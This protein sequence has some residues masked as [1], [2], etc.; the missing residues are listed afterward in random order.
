MASRPDA[1][2]GHSVGELSAAHVAGVLNLSDAAMLVCARGRLMQRCERGGS[3]LSLE[4][5]E[6]EVR[7]ELQ[8]QGPLEVDIAGLNGPRQTVISGAVEAVQALA[9]AFARQGRRII[10]L[11]VSHAFHSLHME[12]MLAE[13]ERVAASCTFFPAR[14]PVV[15]LLTG[16]LASD[17]ELSSPRYWSR[18]VRE[19][20]RFTDGIAALHAEGVRLFLECGPDAVLSALGTGC[21]PESAETRF[22]SSL[23]KGQSD[24]LAVQNA[25]AQLHVSG[26]EPN[27]QAVF[28]GARPLVTLPTYAFQHERHWLE[29]GHVRADL[30]PIGMSEL[31]HRVLKFAVPMADSDGSI[32]QGRSATRD[33]D[34][35]LAVAGSR[36]LLFAP[37]ATLD[38][39]L[40]AAQ[41]LGE[42]EVR[43]LELLEPVTCPED[44]AVQFQLSIGKSEPSGERHFS[45]HARGERDG[46]PWI[47]HAQ[48][49]MGARSAMSAVVIEELRQL[50]SQDWQ[51]LD[52]QAA[53]FG[54]PSSEAASWSIEAGRT[55]NAVF[56]RLQ[57]KLAGADSPWSRPAA[58][59]RV[60]AELLRTLTVDSTSE[61][62]LLVQL[63]SR[64]VAP[65]MLGGELRVR[66]ALHDNESRARLTACNEEGLLLAEGEVRLRGV[67]LAELAPRA[68][69]EHEHLYL[70][71]H[72]TT[73]PGQPAE[74]AHHRL[75]G[76]E[77]S[78]DSSRGSSQG[79]S[80]SAAG[81]TRRGTAFCACS[82]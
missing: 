73:L 81:R 43:S 46:A 42:H 34:W 65:R 31:T 6:S 13:Y 33:R 9:D 80:G 76:L 36:E 56:V 69:S 26:K 30:E 55:E 58:L 62:A 20:V 40:H 67:E 10:R 12:S 27:W 28:D 59:D 21:L 53:G 24:A 15:S 23:R 17:A 50:R 54:S 52:L 32:L 7:T 82:D 51:A 16:K 68:E 74:S 19:A 75:V 39:A 71:E 37:A 70:V 38:M 3:M 49:T 72:R 2:A 41:T 25:L 79:E 61:R 48:G 35:W 64:V 44:E 45:L 11:K 5:S 18:Q 47:R 22:V 66:I 4:A 1:L 57:G 14:V 29:V 8:K 63:W 77:N 78:R 60:L